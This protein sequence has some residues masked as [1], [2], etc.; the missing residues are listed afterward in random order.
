MYC[1]IAQKDGFICPAIDLNNGHCTVFTDEGVL[2]KEKHG[3]CNYKEMRRPSTETEKRRNRVGQQ[4]QKK[5][6]VK[7]R[8]IE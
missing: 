4:K 6:K 5:R 2:A 8:N 3:L 7:A 1:E